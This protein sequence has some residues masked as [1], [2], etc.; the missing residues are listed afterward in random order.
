M[1]IVLRIA[2]RMDTGYAAWC[3]ALPGCSVRGRTREE[4]QEKIREAVAGYLASLDV[5]LP[6]ELEQR[7]HSE[8]TP[9]AA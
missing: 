8:M 2:K 5:A 3:P 4:A 9:P 6:R 7:F 1:K